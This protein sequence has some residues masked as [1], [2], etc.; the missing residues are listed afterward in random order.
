MTITE[1]GAPAAEVSVDLEEQRRARSQRIERVGRRAKYL[2]LELERLHNHVADLG[3]LPNDVGFGIAQAQAQRLRERLLQTVLELIQKER[4]GESV[5]RS[6]LRAVTQM[7]TDLGRAPRPSAPARTARCCNARVTAHCGPLSRRRQAQGVRGRL[8]EA[9][10]RG[11]RGLLPGSP[12]LR[13]PRDHARA[14]RH[15]LARARP[16][17]RRRSSTFCSA[18]ARSTCGARS[19][20]WT[21]RWRA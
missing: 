19:S 21:R 9:V 15:P 4:T 17:R 3:A 1:T 20:A 6:L 16:R 13:C 14:S 5:D 12:P 7:L 18:T 10:P 8:R 11:L 2:L